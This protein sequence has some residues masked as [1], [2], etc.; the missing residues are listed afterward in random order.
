MFL[1]RRHSELLVGF[2]CGAEDRPTELHTAFDDTGSVI[3]D[4]P[5]EGSRRELL[6]SVRRR[7]EECDFVETQADLGVRCVGKVIERAEVFYV[8]RWESRI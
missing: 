6:C 5:F 2:A 4:D 8:R 3:A 7:V 1:V